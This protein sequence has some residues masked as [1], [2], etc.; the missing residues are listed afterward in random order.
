MVLFTHDELLSVNT[1]ICYHATYF[2]YRTEFRYVWTKH[3]DFDGQNGC[4]THFARNS[5]LQYK[6]ISV[7]D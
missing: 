5:V 7:T 3:G 2:E 4:G 6:I 1:L